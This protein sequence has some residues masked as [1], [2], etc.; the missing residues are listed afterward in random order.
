MDLVRRYGS[1]PASSG[2]V[3][4]GK[5]RVSAAAV[6]ACCALVGA[7]AAVTIPV[8]RESLLQWRGGW[9]AGEARRARKQE[10]SDVV[11]APLERVARTLGNTLASALQDGSTLSSL[12]EAQGV[13]PT[14]EDKAALGAGQVASVGDYK[15][16][17][18]SDF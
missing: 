17:V 7:L 10:L 2:E 14:W 1:L 6:G 3:H 11:T 12:E 9:R 5:L 16:F 18:E 4:R 8:G 15:C 13:V